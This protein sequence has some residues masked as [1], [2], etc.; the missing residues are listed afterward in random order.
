MSYQRNDRFRPTSTGFRSYAAPPC[1]Q[2]P[3]TE[4]RDTSDPINTVCNPT[5]LAMVFGTKQSFQNL[6]EPTK[7]LARGTLFADLDKP[8]H[9]SCQ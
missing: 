2:S 3:I 5:T 4:A 1:T 6:Y 8:F 7:A 9:P